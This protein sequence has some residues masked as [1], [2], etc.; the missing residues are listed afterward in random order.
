MDSEVSFKNSYNNLGF[1]KRIDT[2]KHTLNYGELVLTIAQPYFFTKPLTSEILL[3]KFH[4]N[5]AEAAD[6]LQNLSDVLIYLREGM[7]SELEGMHGDEESVPAHISLFIIHSL[8][9][10][11]ASVQHMLRLSKQFNCLSCDIHVFP[12]VYVVQDSLDVLIHQY[13]DLFVKKY[14]C[15]GEM[16]IFLKLWKPV[17]N[18]ILK[19]GPS[20]KLVASNIQDKLESRLGIS[21]LSFIG[22]DECAICGDDIYEDSDFAVLDACNHLMCAC[23]AKV[24]YMRISILYFSILADCC[25]IYD[26]LPRIP[27]IAFRKHK[28]FRITYFI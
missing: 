27:S 11:K 2:L 1:L 26:Y 12:Y 19:K 21:Y 24:S 13:F 20:A 14:R 7:R 9:K 6:Y 10:I 17:L 3:F 28:R 18:G 5:P 4:H 15:T 8:M 22:C 25:F 16:N 23:C